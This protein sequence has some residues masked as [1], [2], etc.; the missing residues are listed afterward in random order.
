MSE[1]QVNI[2]NLSEIKSLIEENNT[3]LREAIQAL[4]ILSNQISLQETPQLIPQPS[5]RHYPGYTTPPRFGFMSG[6]I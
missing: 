4:K 2:Q 1:E 6:N 5:E 3:A